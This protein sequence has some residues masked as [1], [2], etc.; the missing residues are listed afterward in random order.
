MENSENKEINSGINIEERRFKIKQIKKYESE[1]STVGLT[2]VLSGILSIMI[3]TAA[4]LVADQDISKLEPTNIDMIHF[5]AVSVFGVI[6]TVTT[7]TNSIKNACMKANY[8]LKV[9]ELKDELD[10][11]YGGNIKKEKTKKVKENKKEE[12]DIIEFSFEEKAKEKIIR[13]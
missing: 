2:S 7:A 5:I 3:A 4:G 11:Y 9:E 1:S 12:E 13:I 8:D 10:F 6:G